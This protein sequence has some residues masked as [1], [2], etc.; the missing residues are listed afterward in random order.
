MV[1]VPNSKLLDVSQKKIAEIVPHIKAN[2]Q[3]IKQKKQNKTFFLIHHYYKLIF[4]YYYFILFY[5]YSFYT[6]Y[7]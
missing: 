3:N 7:K 2:D 4:S 6:Y 1:D 5:F